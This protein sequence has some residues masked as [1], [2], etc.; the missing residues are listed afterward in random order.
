M[1]D[2]KESKHKELIAIIGT[3]AA[4]V[5]LIDKIFNL[6]IWSKLFRLIKENPIWLWTSGSIIYVSIIVTGFIF[7]WLWNPRLVSDFHET[8]NKRRTLFLIRL[9][10]SLCIPLIFVIVLLLVFSPG[11]S[12]EVSNLFPQAHKMGPALIRTYA[13]NGEV[14]YSF[15]KETPPNGPD[16]Y[17]RITFKTNGKTAEDNCGWVFYLL[18]G[19]DFSNYKQL[20]FL[21]RGEHGDEVVGL[22]AKDAKGREVAVMLDQHY[23]RDGSITANWQQAIVPLD[24]FGDVD[25]SLMENFSIFYNGLMAATRPQVIYVG[26]FQLK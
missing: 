25:F 13:T 16:G 14:N 2:E 19:I 10:C 6:G 24:H 23:L 11:G 12:Y 20:R 5:A 21:I 18:K 4:I 15:H 22:K 26:E 7:I 9:T 1:K 8:Y 3:I 17:A